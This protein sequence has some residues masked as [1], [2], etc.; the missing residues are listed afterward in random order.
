VFPDPRPSR[1][2]SSK[3]GLLAWA[4]L[5]SALALGGCGGLAGDTDPAGAV[6]EGEA[7]ALDQAARMLDEQRVPRGALPD[8]EPAPRETMRAQPQPG[9]TAPANR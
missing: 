1:Q 8:P 6:S 7:A 5:F 2:W 4:S 3:P 9:E